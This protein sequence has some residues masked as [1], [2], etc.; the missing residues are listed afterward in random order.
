MPVG[1]LITKRRRTAPMIRMRQFM[2]RTS[3]FILS[4]VVVVFIVLAGSGGYMLIEGWNFIDSLFMTI[5]SLSTVG[6]GE[7]HKLSDAGRIYTIFLI[8]SGVGFFLYMA[9]IV[10]QVMVE[11]QI[12]KVLGRRKLDKKIGRLTGHYIVCGYGRIGNVVHQRISGHT[13]HQKLELVVIEKDES[14]AEEM[15]EKGILYVQGDATEEANLLKAGI[16]NARG[17]IA[18]LATDTDN[19][20][21]VLTARQLNPDLS[22]ISRASHYGVKSKLM[23]AGAN[24]VESP[25][26]TGG[27]RMAQRILHPNV[28]NFLDFALELNRDDIQMGEMRVSKSSKLAGL[29]LKDSGIRLKFDIIVMAIQRV[30]GRMRFNPSSENRIKPR[31]MIIAMGKIDD[32][33]RLEK[34]LNP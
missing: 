15:D 14:F 25:Y 16:L 5:I 24:F 22:I 18:S 29:M 4:N 6:Y 9:G 3:Y 32:L 33:N 7:I 2:G 34:I 26:E 19:V 27:M 8:I 20:F 21:L 1:N 17:L 11:G 23:A 30:D 28:T 31:D 12:R 13:G 10:V